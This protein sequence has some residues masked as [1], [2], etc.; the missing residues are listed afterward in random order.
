[1]KPSTY[2]ERW[3]VRDLARATAL[4]GSSQACV[5]A[6]KRASEDLRGQRAQKRASEDL[7]AVHLHEESANVSRRREMNRELTQ[8]RRDVAVQRRRRAAL[9][10]SDVLE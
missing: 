5:R 6:Q 4:D 2:S 9:A 1:M 8:L 7:W 3:K 10:R